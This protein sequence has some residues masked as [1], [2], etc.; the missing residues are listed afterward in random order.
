[1]QLKPDNAALDNLGQ[2][3]EH[4]RAGHRE[5]YDTASVSSSGSFHSTL[6][7]LE[8][9]VCSDDGGLMAYSHVFLALIWKQ[10]SLNSV[11]HSIPD[12]HLQ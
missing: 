6:E 2:A 12:F 11:Q 5:D 1:M 10:Q 7:S 4:E 3:V 9:E 8:P